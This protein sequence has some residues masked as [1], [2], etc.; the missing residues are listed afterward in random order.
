MSACGSCDDEEV[1]RHK[2]EYVPAVTE[3]TCTARGYTTYTCGCGRD[4]VADYTD[5]LGHEYV[6]DICTRCGWIRHDHNY[7]KTTVEPT[8]TDS[9]YTRGVCSICGASYNTDFVDP[10]G[11]DYDNGTCTRCGYFNPEEHEHVYTAEST[12]EPDCTNQGY[13]KHICGCGHSYNSDYTDP[14]GHD[15]VGGKCT[16]C[17]TLKPS[18]LKFTLSADGTFYV[19]NGMEEVNGTEIIIP[20]EYNGKPVKCIGEGAF[21]NSGIESIILP[22]SVV[23]INSRAFK[24]CSGLKNLIVCGDVT[25]IYKNSFEGCYNIENVK[26]SSL[27]LSNIPKT[28]LKTV[29]ITD[30]VDSGLFDGCQN[31]TTATIGS[32]AKSI[33]YGA[34]YN[35]NS[36]TT[37]NMGNSVTSVGGYA[38]YGCTNLTSISMSQQLTSIGEQSFYNCNNLINIIIPDKVYIIGSSAFVKCDRLTIYCEAASRPNG[39]NADWNENCPVVWDCKNN[40]VATD[41]NIYIDEG[42]LKYLIKDGKA[43]VAK[44]ANDIGN[45]VIIPSTI[46]YNGVTYTVTSICDE[47]FRNCYKVTNITIPDSVVSIGYSAFS[48]CTYLTNLVIPDS[49]TTISSWAFYHCSSLTSVTI[50]NGVTT[51]GNYVF[52]DCETLTSVTLGN[53]VASIGEYAFNNCTKLVSVT[54]P[55]SMISFGGMAFYRCS[56]L[57]EII[58]RGTQEQWGE[59]KKGRYWDRGTGL[60]IVHCIDGNVANK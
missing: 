13:T 35:C 58:Y 18:K 8:C 53:S 36:L 55:E 54:I 45:E 40:N 30:S 6:G 47:A 60:Y 34:F 15:F 59:I 23:Y 12:V 29:E 4:Y 33:G 44:Q 38:F 42:G 28:K 19:F 9:G 31:L 49:V 24:E 16:R 21:N 48:E 22:D 7:E 43:G 25:Q 2:H 27:V 11:H 51:I 32:G 57:K 3:P 39:W 10:V 46:L 52:N 37:V 26:A 41:G 1:V 56:S 17:E 14:L 5:P 50:G 20:S